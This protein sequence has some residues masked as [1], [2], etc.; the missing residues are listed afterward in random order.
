MSG[1]IVLTPGTS[2]IDSFFC[3]AINIRLY[4]R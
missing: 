4:L 3:S 1:R 2:K